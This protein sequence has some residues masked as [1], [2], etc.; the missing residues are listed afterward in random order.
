M[1]AIITPGADHRRHRRP[2]EVPR[3][4]RC[5][6]ALWLLLVYAPGRPLGVQPRPAGCSSAA[7]ST[8]PAA[9]SSTSTPASP[10]WRVV[11]VL[12]KRKGWPER[13]DAAALPAADAARHRHPVVRL[14]RLQR[15]LRPR[16]QRPRRPGASSTPTSPPRPAMLGWLIVETLK[17]GHATTLGAASGAVAG[18][19]AITP[20]RRLR[21][22][23]G[24]DRHRLRR[25]R[26]LLPR[27]PAEVQVRLRRLA[28]RRR[29][30]P[31]RRHRRLAPARPLRRHGGQ[32]A[33]RRRR[34][35][36]AAAATC[37]ATSS[38]PSVRRSC[39]RSSSRSSSP[40]SSTS[41]SGCGSRDDEEA[42]GLDLSQHAE[43]A[44]AFGEL[45]QHGEDRR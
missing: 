11:L 25:R 36:S 23:H 6:S 15:R 39:S 44:Y 10:P 31:R 19:V 43:T 18:L 4:R 16:R 21:R 12:G 14:V 17:D 9:P 1:F 33:R 45:G 28:R 37:S 26:R 3:L 40:R 38:S 27:H 8:S 5:S 20:V 42:E 35:S 24:A 2:D 7:R 34:C 32:L 30:A 29:R 22:R 41:P 13:G